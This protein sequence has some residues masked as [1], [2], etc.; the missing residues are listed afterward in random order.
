[1]VSL[2][3]TH[4]VCM[5][6]CFCLVWPYKHFIF[7]WINKPIRKRS[8]KRPRRIS[9][10]L[11]WRSSRFPATWTLWRDPSE[12]FLKD[13]RS[14]RKLWRVT[15]RYA[16]MRKNSCVLKS[17]GNNRMFKSF[18]I[19]TLW[20]EWR[21][22]EGLRAGLLGKDEEGGAALPGAEGSCRGEN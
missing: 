17:D 20:L 2:Y 16:P 21:D 15:K 22:A 14:T 19:S 10:R 8:G 7:S 4:V 18:F 3:T 9:A 6:L 1:M 5:Q 11:W 13:L 12:S